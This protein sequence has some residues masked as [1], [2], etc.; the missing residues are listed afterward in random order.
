MDVPLYQFRPKGS[1]VPLTVSF[2]D[3]SGLISSIGTHRN[4]L[5]SQEIAVKENSGGR[6][7]VHQK[8]EEGSS[9]MYHYIKFY[10]E[11]CS[12]T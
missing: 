3:H 4:Q 10:F 11:K 12:A 1:T 6:N 5:S 7:I 9:N 2:L 8:K